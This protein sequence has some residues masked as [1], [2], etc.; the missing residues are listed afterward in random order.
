MVAVR[1][2]GAVEGLSLI[3]TSVVGQESAGLPKCVIHAHARDHRLG[4]GPMVVRMFG[5]LSLYGTRGH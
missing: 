2:E 1:P 5:S 3:I 4:A